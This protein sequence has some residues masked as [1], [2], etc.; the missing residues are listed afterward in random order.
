MVWRSD[1]GRGQDAADAGQEAHV[2]H[3]VG[4]VEDD[5]LNLAQLHEVA[6]EEIAETAGSG[7]QHLRALTDGV[8][9]GVFAQ[10]AHDH[11][12]FQAAAARHFGE[13]LID[14]DGELPRGAQ[15]E[16]ACPLLVCQ[17]LDERQHESERLAGARLGGGD[18][19]AAGKSRFNCKGLHRCRSGE[20]VFNEVA[21]QLSRD[22]E[23]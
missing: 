7:D 19:V 1:G 6:A 18:D 20:A 4:L 12:G 21:L 17:P 8:Q 15:H 9:L 13:G 5:D 14:L 22:G 10:P 11:G 2:E 23:F 3:A 16:G